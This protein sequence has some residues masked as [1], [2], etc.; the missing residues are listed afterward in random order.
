MRTILTAYACF[1]PVGDTQA[2]W[3]LN[4]R[5]PGLRLRP[6][7]IEGMDNVEIVDLTCSL[8]EETRALAVGLRQLDADLDL[9]EERLR[10]VEEG[11]R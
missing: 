7:V 2:T 10:H 9:L 11:R 6:P 4:P 8:L 3:R 5:Q 1:E